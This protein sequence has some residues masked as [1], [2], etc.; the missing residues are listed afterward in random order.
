MTRPSRRTTCCTE[1]LL[2][3]GLSLANLDKLPPKGAIL[4]A[5]PLKI[6][7]GTGSPDPGAGAGAEGLTRWPAAAR[8]HRQRA[9]TRW[10]RGRCWREGDARAR[11]GARGRSAAAC[12]PAEI[13]LPGFHHDVMAATFVLFLTSPAHAALA[14]TSPGTG[15]TSATPHPTAVLRPTAR[16]W[17]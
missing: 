6:K 13:T 8:H 16:R 9:S 5:A 2:R 1:Q 12:G 10:S 15:S 4:I 3:P 14:P 11:A 17:C 7:N